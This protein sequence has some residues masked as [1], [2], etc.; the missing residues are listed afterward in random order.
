[1][2]ELKQL[3]QDLKIGEDATL[4]DIL[5]F[6][7]LCFLV[8]LSHIWLKFNFPSGIRTVYFILFV[9][10]A[11]YYRN[12]YH[13]KKR[14]EKEAKEKEKL[15]EQEYN[16]TLDSLYHIAKPILSKMTE[17]ELFVLRKFFEQEALDVI[18]D[19]SFAIQYLTPVHIA[20]NINGKI[21]PIGLNIRIGSTLTHTILTI[22]EMYADILDMYFKEQE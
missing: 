10:S 2:E 21:G 1:M 3:I 4:K 13:R 18:F 6:S 15:E 16:E 17:S 9:F 8:D 12:R 19:R 5:I 20:N 11:F 22:N 14:L 7:I